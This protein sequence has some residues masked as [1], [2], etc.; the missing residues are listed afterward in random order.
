MIKPWACVD[1]TL[2]NFINFIDFDYGFFIH[3]IGLY[4]MSF[5]RTV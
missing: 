3:F 5:E 2:S 1:G 4:C